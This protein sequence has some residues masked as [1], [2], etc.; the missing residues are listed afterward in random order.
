MES[1]SATREDWARLEWDRRFQNRRRTGVRRFWAE[2]RRRLA[3]GE[4]GT[5]NWTPEQVE[6][7]LAGRRPT[8]EGE[9]MTGHHRRSALEHPQLAND[10]ENIYPATTTEHLQRWH[11]GDFQNPTFGEPFNPEIPEEF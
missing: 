5:R 10:P 6:E 1:R 2:E 8:F 7:I 11:G 3:E 4:S 9:T